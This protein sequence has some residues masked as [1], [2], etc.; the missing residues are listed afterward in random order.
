M[1]VEVL[2]HSAVVL[3]LSSK[4]KKVS[5]SY[6]QPSL[7]EAGCAE[8][9][10]VICSSSNSNSGRLEQMPS[11]LYDRIELSSDYL[12]FKSGD[13][14]TAVAV[15]YLPIFSGKRLTCLHS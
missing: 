8:R 7:K 4:G 1:A 10:K 15:F 9:R 11:C 5:E 12:L 2:I 14:I 13:F 3:R 6:F